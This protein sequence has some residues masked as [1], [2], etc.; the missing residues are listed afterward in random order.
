MISP[1]NFYAYIRHGER[2]DML[3]STDPSKFVIPRSQEN[4]FD[5]PLTKV[6][7]L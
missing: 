5:V 3:K 2:A 7:M 6:G 1:F 4:P